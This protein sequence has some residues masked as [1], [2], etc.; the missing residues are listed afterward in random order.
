MIQIEY[1][2]EI[3]LK[4]GK[5]KT[6]RINREIE[7]ANID[8]IFA[9][10]VYVD[11]VLYRRVWMDGLLDYLT[12]RFSDT[13][14]SKIE[15]IDEMSIFTIRTLFDEHCYLDKEKTAYLSHTESPTLKRKISKRELLSFS[16][17][18]AAKY[19][20]DMGLDLEEFIS[21]R[22]EDYDEGTW[23]FTCKMNPVQFKCWL[24]WSENGIYRNP[25]GNFETMDGSGHSA[26]HCSISKISKEYADFFILNKISDLF[27][28]IKDRDVEKIE[29]KMKNFG[30]DDFSC[31]F[32][33]DAIWED[34]ENAIMKICDKIGIKFEGY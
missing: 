17:S 15:F 28:Y 12:E 13:D 27:G 32:S 31:V 8:L 22:F 6:K 21:F 19:A 29:S 30:I 26:I 14:I 4:D 25:S 24:G 18:S 7:N 10:F 23:I 9:D 5:Q 33:D 16:P 2:R 11:N 1:H 20:I 34:Y 3:C